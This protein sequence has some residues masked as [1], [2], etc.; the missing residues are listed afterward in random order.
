MS[1]PFVNSHAVPATNHT[2][3]ASNGKGGLMGSCGNGFFG[4]A[5]RSKVADILDVLIPDCTPALQEDI[6]NIVEYDY[7]NSSSPQLIH[8]II[9]RI[10]EVRLHD[11]GSEDPQSLPS[12]CVTHADEPSTDFRP[13]ATAL[14]NPSCERNYTAAAPQVFSSFA[15]R[16]YGGQI[17]PPSSVSLGYSLMDMHFRRMS[18]FGGVTATVAANEDMRNFLD[19]RAKEF[20][21]DG[22]LVLAFISKKDD[23]DT[24][25][26][27]PSPSIYSNERGVTIDAASGAIPARVATHA[28]RPSHSWERSSSLSR[29]SYG[30]DNSK[31]CSL[32]SGLPALLAPCMQRLVSTGLINGD[33]AHKLLNVGTVLGL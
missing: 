18:T 8:D 14:S 2:A 32:W 20:K 9:Q 19:A 33:T 21:Q 15:G 6:V 25:T 31:D 17:A 11:T 23:D 12:Y 29:R 30:F 27:T 1:I 3:P 7:S 4:R 5:V 24:L 16:H 13:M 22:V 26:L 10:A 28:K